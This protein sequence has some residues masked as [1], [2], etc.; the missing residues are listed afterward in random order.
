M[1]YCL[2]WGGGSITKAWLG[3]TSVLNVIEFFDES[4]MGILES[5]L[6]AK[7]YL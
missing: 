2:D 3:D 6:P 1:D 7:V 5:K 4:N